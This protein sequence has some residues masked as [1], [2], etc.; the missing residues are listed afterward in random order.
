MR[1]ALLVVDRRFALSD[2]SIFTEGA[3]GAET[4][5]RY[6]K[7][8]GEFIVAGRA[9]RNSSSSRSNMTRLPAAAGLRVELLPDISGL[10]LRAAQLSL[11][12]TQLIRLLGEVDCAIVRLPKRATGDQSS[13]QCTDSAFL[14]YGKVCSFG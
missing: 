9:M 3:I 14:Q 12:R 8:F 5:D 2:D 4:G 6:L 11:A 7:W 13:S 1:R 10:A